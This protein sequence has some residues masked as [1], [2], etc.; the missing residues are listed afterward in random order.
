MNYDLE[1]RT[2][3]E[4]E[5][6]GYFMTMDNSELDSKKRLFHHGI[7][8]YKYFGNKFNQDV[9]LT[10]LKCWDNNLPAD[11]IN[12]INFRPDEY[13]DKDNVFAKKG[14]DTNVI[15]M[16]NRGSIFNSYALES[17]LWV[18][19]QYILQ[20]YWN[21]KATEILSNQWD[22]R[23]SLVV[24]DNIINGY[25]LLFEKI[26]K[27]FKK[28]ESVVEKQRALLERKLKGEIITVLSGIPAVDKFTGGWHKGELIIGAGR[29]G[30]GKT[31]M[32]LISAI[33]SAFYYKKKIIFWSL[34]MPKV[35]LMNKVAAHQLKLDYNR[36]K[37]FDYDQET[38]EMVFRFYEFMESDESNLIIIDKK[39]VS[40]MSGIDKKV[41]QLKP[42]LLI[43]DYLQ[44]AGI[45]NGVIKKAG[46]REQEIAYI[47]KSFKGIAL[48][49]DIPVLALSQLSRSVELRSNKRPQLSD[50]R[51]S[52]SIEQDADIV[53]FYYRDAYYKDL[54]KMPVQ[55][56]EWWNLEMSFAKGR[57]LGTKTIYLNA[58][59]ITYEVEEGFK[60]AN[61][62]LPPAPPKN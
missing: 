56:W 37:N 4:D 38:M 5:I 53:I 26:T 11:L 43:A 45:E 23:D 16:N 28:A 1:T 18:F 57:D 52:G 27:Q 39:E 12:V 40:T 59:F 20:D 41:K 8:D 24:S 25:N 44:L 47:S 55:D 21:E 62:A 48:D 10:M 50:L 33:K 60:T 42:D 30:M 14:F 51:E 9:F 34:E 29:P 22:F 35:Q 7:D 17:K 36:I 58:N 54:L 19:K 46:N 2:I 15:M 13:R 32:S 61:D 31:T 6:L 49:H 3:L